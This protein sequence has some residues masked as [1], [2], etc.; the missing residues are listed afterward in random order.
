M[1]MLWGGW[2]MSNTNKH[3]SVPLAHLWQSIPSN[4]WLSHGIELLRN[5]HED[6]GS[7]FTSREFAQNIVQIE[8]NMSFSDIGAQHKNGVAK[9]ACPNNDDTCS[10]YALAIHD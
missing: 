6:N 10:Y 4:A 7:T 9:R 1:I 8:Q 5:N 3:C 2:H